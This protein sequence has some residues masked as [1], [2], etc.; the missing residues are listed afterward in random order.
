MKPIPKELR[1]YFP[2]VLH[3]DRPWWQ[4]NGLYEPLTRRDGREAWFQREQDKIDA[5]IPLPPPRVLVGQVWAHPHGHDSGVMVTATIIFVVAPL[6]ADRCS[7][8][9]SN[10]EYLSVP[11]LLRDG[12]L[13]SCPF[14]YAPW[15][16]PEVVP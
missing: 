10:G 14:G 1:G 2:G 15:S 11:D 6:P 5:A 12:F 13:L 8:G 4:F 9:F 7:I 16:G 3:A